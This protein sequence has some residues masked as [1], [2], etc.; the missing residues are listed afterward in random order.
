MTVSN[1]PNF[2]S[3]VVKW[4]GDCYDTETKQHRVSENQ[5][6]H[7]DQKST[8]WLMKNEDNVDLL[9][10]ENHIVHR[11]LCSLWTDSESVCLPKHVETLG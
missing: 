7:C 2:F 5:L 8:A 6:V 1:D 11:E 9:F 3:K 10:D 4:D